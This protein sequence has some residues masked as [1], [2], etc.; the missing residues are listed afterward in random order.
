[1]LHI[2]KIFCYLTFDSTSQLFYSY[3]SLNFMRNKDRILRWLKK[4][5][6][7]KDVLKFLISSFQKPYSKIIISQILKRKKICLE[8]GAGNRKG[9]GDWVTLDGGFCSDI[10]WDLRQ[11]IPFPNNSLDKIYT[12]HCFEHIPLQG[13][14]KLIRNCHSKLKEGGT[15][16]VCVPNARLY[17]DAYVAGEQ[18]IDFKDK[19]LVCPSTV[20]DT[21]SPID[22]VNLIAYLGGQHCY[23]FD[24]VNLVNILKKNGFSEVRIRDFQED[25]DLKERDHESIYAIARK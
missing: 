16:S 4:Y 21:G 9:K 25:L 17:I 5:K 6:L 24:Q 1:M 12:S 3:F 14:E 2:N 23:M 20:C 8:I 13:L 11:G 15:L 10:H 22:Q 18:F 19:S 7:I